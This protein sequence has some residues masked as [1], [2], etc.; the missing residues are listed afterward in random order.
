LPSF[1]YEATSPQGG[2]TRGVI[3]APSRAAAVE[4]LLGAGQ[5]PMRVVEQGAGAG[6]AGAG[7]TFG[8]VLP[9]WNVRGRRLG[10]LRELS[11]LLR[12][13]LSVERALTA[14]QG[15]AKTAR[16][17]TVLAQ[18]IESL[19][20]GEP[21][22]AAMAR[23]GPLFPEA[24]RKLV[25]AGEASGRLTEVTERLAAAEASIRCCSSSS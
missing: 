2:V 13:G 3:E 23:S 6:A 14:M 22:S 20:A 24:M 8:A 7:L 19:R 11:L 18:L 4:R 25:A 16:A 5:T 15:L 17:R 21:L 1:A 12:A 9:E 10:F